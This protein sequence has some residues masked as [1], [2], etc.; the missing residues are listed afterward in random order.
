MATKNAETRALWLQKMLKYGDK[1][2]K[3][4]DIAKDITL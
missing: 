3:I 1:I 4:K 2:A